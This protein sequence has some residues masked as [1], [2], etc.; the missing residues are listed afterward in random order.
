[1]QAA[2]G[3]QGEIAPEEVG[4]FAREGQ[5]DACSGDAVVKAV[6]DAVEGLEDGG[7]RCCRYAGLV[8]TDGLPGFDM[9]S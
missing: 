9:D 3:C 1:M 7:S 8:G 6:A 2:V 5:A 4:Q